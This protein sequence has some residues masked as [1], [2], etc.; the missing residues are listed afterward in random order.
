M[1]GLVSRTVVLLIVAVVVMIGLIALFIYYG[2]NPFRIVKRC[3][4]VKLCYCCCGEHGGY[5]S[6]QDCLNAFSCE[7]DCS[8]IDCDNDCP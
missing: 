2:Y 4:K 7:G 3:D 6:S 1:K 8:S 5:A